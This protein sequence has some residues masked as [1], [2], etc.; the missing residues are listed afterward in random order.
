MEN[1]SGQN[2]IRAIMQIPVM[3]VALLWVIFFPEQIRIGFNTSVWDMINRCPAF[4]EN[5]TKN[6]IKWMWL[7]FSSSN[8]WEAAIF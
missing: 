6:Y 2:K 4:T 8:Q 3:K 5:M 1:E 7:Y